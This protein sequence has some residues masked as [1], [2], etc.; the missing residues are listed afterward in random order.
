MKA[1]RL[2]AI[3]F[4]AFAGQA[5]PV[6]VSVLSWRATCDLVPGATGYVWTTPAGVIRT[7]TNGI[8]VFK[9]PR[10]AIW[11]QAR[12]LAGASKATKTTF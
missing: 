2:I 10:G 7:R 11:V 3:L 9:S 1:W 4:M 8:P 5:R 12:N 6:P